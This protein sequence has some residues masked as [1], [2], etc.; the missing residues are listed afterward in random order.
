MSKSHAE[1]L[2]ELPE[3]KRNALLRDFTAEQIEALEYDWTFWG[4]P[5]QQEPSESH[6]VWL[7]LA[8]RGWGKTRTGAET[9]RQWTEE[10]PRIACV[11]PTS[12]DA[13][14]VMVEGESGLLNIGPP[15]ERPEWQ[16]SKNKLTYPN[17]SVVHFY[18]ATEPDRLR[19]PQYH[20][21]WCDEL[22]AWP[23]LDEPY[24]AWT[25]LN[26]G[27]R[28]GNSPRI[29]VTTTPR[30]IKLVRH[31]ANEP[32]TI[33][34]RGS[35]YD[36]AA[37]L[38]QEFISTIEEQFHGT[39]VG[40]QEIYAE[41]LDDV[42]GAL[43][44]RWLLERQ[45]Y[46]AR[47]QGAAP[48]HFVRVVLGVDPATTNDEGSDETG[49]VVVAKDPSGQAFVLA[50]ASMHGS[51]DEWASA[52]VRAAKAFDVDRVVG[53][54]NNGGDLIERNIKTVDPNIPYKSVRASRG[55]IKRAEPVAA[56]YE[57]RRVWHLGMFPE[58]EDQMSRFTPD[59]EFDESPDHADALVWALTELMLLKR[60][61]RPFKKIRL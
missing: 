4:R 35:T 18:P 59:G 44:P 10:V 16:P 56:L 60:E 15:A 25:Q 2:A 48:K 7:I 49:I 27:L 5:E 24:N 61:P 14:D 42:P 36:N 33:I 3:A 17:G 34:T 45:R 6:K 22:A 50:D 30:P 23:H 54:V 8:G 9:V 53:E 28:L 11:A 39:R 38:A 1:L 46:D 41:I 20:R 29:V 47:E 51:P 13:R 26:L 57:Q 55:K 37:N 40:R 12:A 32:S 43:W 58:L 52:V 31:L 19:G 21:A